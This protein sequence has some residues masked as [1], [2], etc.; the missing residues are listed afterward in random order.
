MAGACYGGVDTGFVALGYAKVA[1]LGVV[2]GVTELL[3]VSSTAHMRII[4]AILGWPDPGA[5]L[6]AAMQLAALAAVVS[7]FRADV[8]NL[9]IGS[10]RAVAQRQF[11][12]P[13]LRLVVWIGVATIPILA[14]GLALAPVLNACGSPL[15]SIPAIG[16]ACLVIGL[17]LAVA[18]GLAGHRRTMDQATGRDALIVGLAQVGALIPGVSRSGSTLT[19]A[20]W[21]PASD[22]K[23]RPASHSS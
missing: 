12:N 10:G 4:P 16:V 6:S 5:A 13:D 20:F 23:R 14:T 7:Y 17:L 18:E 22:A 21:A 2:Q 1:A 19:A 9:V 8:S 3:P 11:R 15:R